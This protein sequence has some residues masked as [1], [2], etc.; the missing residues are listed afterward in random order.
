M[1]SLF[2][3]LRVGDCTGARANNVAR[4]LRRSIS[5]N[6]R[7]ALCAPCALGHN[8][9]RDAN[10]GR[11]RLGRR[12]G[13]GARLRSLR[14]GRAEDLADPAHR[15]EWLARGYAGE[16]R[17]LHDARRADPA[18][19]SPARERHRL[20]AQLQHAQPYS[21]EAAAANA[22]SR[23]PRGWLSR[24]AWGDDYHDVIGEKLEQLVAAMR[25]RF[26]DE[27]S[28]RAYVDTGPVSERAA[29]RAPASVGCAKNTCLINR[30]IGSWLF[31]GVVITS[32]DSFPRSISSLD[33]PLPAESRSTDAT[34]CARL[35]PI[36]AATA[37]CVWTPAPPARSSSPTCSTRAAAS[38]ISPSSCAAASPKSF[39]PRMGWQVFGCD[40]CQDVCPWNRAAPRKSLRF[41]SRAK[42]SSRRNSLW[43]LSL[44][45]EEFR[46]IFRGSAVRRT[47]WRG[48]LRNACIAAGNALA[49]RTAAHAPESA[50]LRQRLA[51]LAASDDAIIAEHAGWAL[52]RI[53]TNSK[54]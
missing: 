21:T 12:P 10:R 41:C 34:R 32:L 38:P 45:E 50:R 46:R 2:R 44:A 15:D 54:V 27:F 35:R 51:Q 14:R 49:P 20:R 4:G 29:A 24:Y 37:A 5:V 16:M 25:E 6:P 39:A 31:L 1:S 7:Q 36:S 17:Y 47:K 22:M 40:I 13:Q 52:A 48:L 30:E 28:A 9:R 26:G 43:L 19:A 53:A 3:N 23:E 18:R 33:R 42:N 11:H 8:H